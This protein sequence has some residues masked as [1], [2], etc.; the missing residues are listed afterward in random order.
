MASW[1]EVRK[2]NNIDCG[3]KGRKDKN[4]GKRKPTKREEGG[5]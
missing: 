2:E 5:T 4:M 1:R 3:D